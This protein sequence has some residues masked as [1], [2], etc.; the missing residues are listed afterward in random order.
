MR[1]RV[2]IE[3]VGNIPNHFFLLFQ[4]YTY[5]TSEKVYLRSC[6]T[7]REPIQYNKSKCWEMISFSYSLGLKR[8]EKE[9][10]MSKGPKLNI[11]K[12]PRLTSFFP[13]PVYYPGSG[14]LIEIIIV[15][16]Q[17]KGRRGNDGERG[18]DPL[19]KSHCWT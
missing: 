19:Y 7:G 12:S 14:I 2:Y 6:V 15:L 13:L 1:S 11:G 4:Q 10:Q 8:N 16:M 5:N 18:G 17:K 9:T 3:V